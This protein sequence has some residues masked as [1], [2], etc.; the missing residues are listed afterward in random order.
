MR[1]PILALAPGRHPELRGHLRPSLAQR[2]LDDELGDVGQTIRDMHHGQA[3]GDL[4]DRHPE[5]RRILELGQGL[6]RLFGV[7]LRHSR[8]AVFEVGGELGTVRRL[9]ERTLIEQLIEQQRMRGE[10][11]DQ[12]IAAATDRHETLPRCGV[13]IEQ[14]EIGRAPADRFDDAQHAP[15]HHE[16]VVASFERS[17]QRRQQL[18]QAPHPRCIESPRKC[19]VAQIEHQPCDLARRLAAAADEAIRQQVAYPFE[20]QRI[21]PDPRERRGSAGSAHRAR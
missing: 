17:E 19:A 20:T 2:L 15:R 18:L 10:L 8:K 6:D 21:V 1:H 16:R 5:H 4:G 12:K 9:D 11:C 3:S 13:F 14:C 7:V